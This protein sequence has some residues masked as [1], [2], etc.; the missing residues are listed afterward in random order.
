V[1]AAQTAALQAG[2]AVTSSGAVPAG[3]PA[4]N[5]S[6]SYK[7]VI[8]SYWGAKRSS[9]EKV[10]KGNAAA[11][12]AV[13]WSKSVMY[14]RPLSG[15]GSA[16]PGGGGVGGGGRGGGGGAPAPAPARAP[17]TDA[18]LLALL[19][20]GVACAGSGAPPPAAALAALAD[21]LCAPAPPQGVPGEPASPPTPAPAPAAGGGAPAPPHPHPHPHPPPAL[22]PMQACGMGGPRS[23]A[24]AAWAPAASTPSAHLREPPVAPLD[25]AGE[26]LAECGRWSTASAALAECRTGSRRAEAEEERAAAR[27]RLGLGAAAAAAAA[28]AAAAAAAAGVPLGTFSGEAAAAAAAAAAAEATPPVEWHGRN[29]PRALFSAPYEAWAAAGA[30]EARRGAALLLLA[31]AGAAVGAPL[32]PAAASA[33]LA[34]ALRGSGAPAGLG[35]AGGLGER[36]MGAR[37][38]ALG[39]RGLLSRRAGGGWAPAGPAAEAAGGLGAPRGAAA[40][41]ARRALSQAAHPHALKAVKAWRS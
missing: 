35:A 3:S 22:L 8:P 36:A 40:A 34:G 21:L 13:R 14:E 33:L 38:E 15:P 39:A 7:D 30:E 19:G 26:A 20:A 5:V 11:E 6:L 29:R 4:A 37:L 31:R 27:K 2:I 41:A 10:D 12:A 28:D 23:A 16:A 18:R 1:H 17:L 25:A 9:G 24:F 32:T